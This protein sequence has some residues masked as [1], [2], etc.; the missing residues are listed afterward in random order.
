MAKLFLAIYASSHVYLE[1]FVSFASGAK[2]LGFQVQGFTD[3]SLLEEYLQKRRAD[4]LLLVLDEDSK[5]AFREHSELI[6]LLNGLDSVVIMMGRQNG[7]AEWESFF[8]EAGYEDRIRYI[9]RYQSAMEILAFV[10]QFFPED[11]KDPLKGEVQSLPWLA[12]MYSP[13]DKVC[14]PKAAAAIM[15]G[16]RKVLYINLEQF[17]GIMDEP[18]SWDNW[19]DGDDHVTL[20]ERSK[21]AGRFNRSGSSDRTAGSDRAGGSDRAEG[22]DRAGGAGYADRE[23]Q[24]RTLAP[25]DW[26]IPEARI[27]TSAHKDQSDCT[28]SDIIYC[29]KQTP[30]KLPEVLNKN[31]GHRFGMDVLSAPEDLADLEEL[32]QGE[33]PEFLRAVAKAGD[34]H[35]IFLDMS[36]FDWKLIGMVLS[37]GE[38]YIPALP[39][40]PEKTFRSVLTRRGGSE[41]QFRLQQAAKMKAFRKYFTDR[42]LEDELSRIRQVQLETD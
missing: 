35:F 18:E 5:Q 14:H 22:S 10:R 4:A 33:W 21:R 19:D 27:D 32:R 24:D 7:C 13:V 15:R 41:Q 28:I 40:D 34:Y 1:R 8:R 31:T 20:Q 30:G 11:Q 9:N 42:G 29:Y 17:S 3:L 36:V 12:G 37:Y 38:L 16:K 6:T 39:Y 2:E 23:Y 26:R 25:S